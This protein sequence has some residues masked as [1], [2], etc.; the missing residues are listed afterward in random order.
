MEAIQRPY[1]PAKPSECKLITHSFTSDSN[2]FFIRSRR[3]MPNLFG[4]SPF[5]SSN[6]YIPRSSCMN[7]IVVQSHALSSKPRIGHWDCQFLFISPPDLQ[8]N[9]VNYRTSRHGKVTSQLQ[10]SVA[11]SPFCDAI[12]NASLLNFLHVYQSKTRPVHTIAPLSPLHCT[13]QQVDFS[14]KRR[15]P[16][17]QTPHGTVHTCCFNRSEQENVKIRR[18]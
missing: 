6:G 2:H 9:A 14:A 10:E 18:L 12:P 17:S 8:L 3:Q 5:S 4:P 16:S 11:V 13:I 1:P 7:Q 15:V